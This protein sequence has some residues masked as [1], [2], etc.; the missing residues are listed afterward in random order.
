MEDSNDPIT[1]K[2]LPQPRKGGSTVMQRPVIVGIG[3]SAGGLEALEGFFTHVPASS[4][5][6]FVVVQHIDP[7]KK[8]MLPELLQRVT[9]FA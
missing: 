7:T 8:G 4:G 3:T 1:V 5:M 2:A 6:A 9:S